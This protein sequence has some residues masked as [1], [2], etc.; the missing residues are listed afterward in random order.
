M[1]NKGIVG[2]FL[3][4]LKSQKNT[5][6]FGQIKIILKI[7]KCKEIKTPHILALNVCVQM[8]KRNKTIMLKVRWTMIRL[9]E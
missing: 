9:K 5:E 8:K 4:T 6:L 7:R 3:E 1:S 2:N